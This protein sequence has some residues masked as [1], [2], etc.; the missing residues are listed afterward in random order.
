MSSRDTA[1]LKI[2]DSLSLSLITNI[3]DD[4]HFQGGIRDLGKFSEGYCFEVRTKEPHGFFQMSEKEPFPE[5]GA[6]R[7]WYL[8]S[9][10][11]EIKNK[12]MNLL[13]KLRLKKQHKVGLWLRKNN[14]PKKQTIANLLPTPPSATDTITVKNVLDGYWVLLQDW[15]SCSKK[16]G[17]G[18]QFQHLM[19]VPPKNGGKPCEGEAL[20]QK[21][22]NQQPCPTVSDAE[23]VLPQKGKEKINDPIIKM[24]PISSRPLRYDKCHLKEGD[25]LFT[26]HKPGVGIENNNERMPSRVVM[27][28]KTVNVFTNEHL[29]TL[30]ATFVIEKTAFKISGRDNK[31]FILDSETAKGEFCKLSNDSK[32]NFIEEWNYDYNLFKIQCHTERDVVS[33]SN[34]EEKELQDE[35]EKKIDSAKLDVIKERT[36]RIQQK[37]QEAPINKVDKLQETAMLAMKKELAIDGLLQ[38]EEME[39]EE[40]ET[41]ELKLQ[42]ENEKKKDEC[43]IKSIKEKEIEDQYNLSKIQ[44]DKEV[45]ELKEQ[46]KQQILQKRKQVKMKILQMRK[47]AMRKKKIYQDEIQTLRTQV[48][49]QLNKHNKEGNAALCFKPTNSEDDKKKVVQYCNSNFMDAS[50][51][52]FKE[53][54]GEEDFCYVCCES[55]FGE[56]HIKERETCYDK[57]E[58][59]PK[60]ST[61][62]GSWQWTE[63]IE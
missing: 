51:N 24:L 33:L 11:E 53:C 16:C 28:E 49:G 50:P 17:G 15:S 41:R 37:V 26:A 32:I 6:D 25:T 35:L 47:R 18:V 10:E 54:L 21:P 59:V 61:R 48:A 34:K 7:I 9:D 52:K 12:M 23:K 43:L 39:R 42:L 58:L 30:L 4:A 38:K 14:P 57:C 27:N 29:E 45:N 13:V 3:P 22:C 5:K 62:A 55:E 2:A 44:Q 46:A 56:M 1:F 36:K 63:T 31:C 20:R 8:C 19:C 60:K 40:A